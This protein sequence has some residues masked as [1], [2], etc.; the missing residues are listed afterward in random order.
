M[1]RW[2]PLLP[3]GG[4]AA[5]DAAILPH[6][7][8]S[9]YHRLFEALHVFWRIVKNIPRGWISAVT[10]VFCA[11]MPPQYSKELSNWRRQVPNRIA[12]GLALVLLTVV[13]GLHHSGA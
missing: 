12:R 11:M 9:A 2:C 3:Q 10:D 13:A 8:S 1:P 5:H 6:F 4:H 7:K